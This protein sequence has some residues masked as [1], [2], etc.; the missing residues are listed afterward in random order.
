[1]KISVGVFFG[2]RSVEH[3]VSVITAMQAIA[4]M[5]EKKYHVVPVYIAKTCEMYTGPGFDKIEAYRDIPALL[6][7]GEQVS[8]LRADGGGLLVP[9]RRKLF[10]RQDGIPLDVAFPIVHGTNAE[11]GTLQGMFESVGMPYVGCDI[12]SSAVCMDK[13]VSK[14]LLR[15]HGL[16]VLPGETLDAF[17]YDNDHTAA[18][19]RLEEAVAYPLIVKPVNLGSSVGIARASDRA[20]L[21][22]ALDAAFAY[23][24]RVIVERA[25]SPL[26]EINCAV[27]GD[28]EGARASVCEEPLGQ[29]EILSYAD[30]YQTSGGKK[31]GMSTQKRRLPADLP[32]ALSRSIQ[33]AAV[34]AFQAL[35]CAGVVRVDFLLEGGV[36]YVN[37]LNTIPGSLSFY[38]W[39]ASGLPFPALTG[40]LL[41]LAFARK[42][43]REGLT[44]TFDTNILSA[45][46]LHFGKK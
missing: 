32:E 45:G 10:G 39:E 9:R 18:V 29:D 36:F 2:G 16:P 23:A 46:H 12:L 38:L 28:C 44:F 22:A 21:L 43:R 35:G 20:S 26:R 3:E 33:S 13:A 25:V 19:S 31:S 6:E 34:D 40:E 17:A 27:L 1:M 42:R 4:A 37:E 8:L 11:D 5:D 24:P 30:K 7:K 14:Q 41:N 15:A